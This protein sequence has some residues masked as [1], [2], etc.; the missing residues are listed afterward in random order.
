MSS[1]TLLTK[2]NGALKRGMM[3]LIKEHKRSRFPAKAVW[4]QSIL[5]MYQMPQGNTKTKIRYDHE[6]FCGDPLEA[7][8]GDT[9][10]QQ[11]TKN[12]KKVRT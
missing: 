11:E 8:G 10:H 12:M 4:T 3:T 6:P 2:V 7:G 5:N 1:R 9:K